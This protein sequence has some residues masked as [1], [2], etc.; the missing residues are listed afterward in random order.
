MIANGIPMVPE[1]PAHDP[2]YTVPGARLALILLLTINLFNYID[3]QVLSATLSSIE[4]HLMPPK[5]SPEGAHN[6]QYLGLLALAFLLAFM[7]F[8]PV[9]GWLAS[10]FPRW[11]L[12]GVGVIIWSLASGASGLASSFWILLLTRCFVGIGE[13]AYGPVAPDMLSDLYPAKKRGYVLSW[14]Y[15]AIPVG[16][17]LGYAL[18]GA[19]GWP[20]AFYL[21]VPPGIILGLLCFLMPEPPR[22]QTDGLQH[23]TRTIHL[24]DYMALLR[25]PS[26]VLNSLG[27]TALMFAM[28]GI[29]HWMP[30]YVEKFRHAADKDHAGLYVGI[31]MVLAG[32]SGT[33]LGGITGDALRT[34][35]SGSY[36]LVSG[37]GMLLCFPLF[38]ASLYVDFPYA[39]GLIFLAAFCMF[40]NTG[41][42]NTILANVTH[43]GLRVQA[44]ALNIFFIHAFGDAISPYVIGTVSDANNHN[45][46]AGFLV[47]SGSI[48]ISAIFWL[49]G[50]PFL[51]RDTANAVHQLD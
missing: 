20:L 31:I 4:D 5:D 29:A 1:T 22:G 3:R 2:D 25:T 8:A 30:Y 9:F 33:V 51:A 13:A 10:R 43:P 21:V 16:A 14:F 23:S 40:F 38:L 50:V 37:V 19:T 48:L 41:P 42:T 26:F 27:M 46:N 36:F 6:E 18:G 47:V 11:K 44:F 7:V 34:R 39:W 35:V 17:A 32:L 49:I 12:V 24:R 45:M 28:G 15:I